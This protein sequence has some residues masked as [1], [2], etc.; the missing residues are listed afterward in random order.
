MHL[1]S[2]I[3]KKN[4]TLKQPQNQPSKS[5]LGGRVLDELLALD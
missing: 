5:K 1:L 3:N 4:Q 2:F